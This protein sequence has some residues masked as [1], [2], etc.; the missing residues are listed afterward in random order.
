MPQ[1]NHAPATEP[2]A[3]MVHISGGSFAMG[4]ERFYPEEAP[5]RMV[6]VDAFYIDPTPVTNAAFAAFVAATGYV[7]EAERAPDPADYPGLDPSMAKAG[8]LVFEKTAGPVDM[9]DVSQWWHFRFGA[10]WRH[11]LGTDSNLDSL[12]DHPVIHVSY[13]DA[14][15][16]ATWAGKR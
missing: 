5:V 3:D 4:S 11:P 8:S 9:D 2:M 16:Y 14:Q 6:S 7:T 15:A 10:D 1:P 13:S 12:E